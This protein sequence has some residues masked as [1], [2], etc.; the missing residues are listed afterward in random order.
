MEAGKILVEIDPGQ[1]HK[2][3]KMIKMIINMTI[4]WSFLDLYVV[5]FKNHA[6]K[7]HF[8]GDRVKMIEIFYAIFSIFLAKNHAPLFQY[9][10][11]IR[12]GQGLLWVVP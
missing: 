3:I 8:K 6:P 5:Y 4:P 11:L 1:D 7:Y 2:L 12:S 9:I 10:I